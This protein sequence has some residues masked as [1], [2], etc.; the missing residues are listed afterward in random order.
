M[1]GQQHSIPDLSAR[2]EERFGFVSKDWGWFERKGFDTTSYCG[3]G[4]TTG[5][6]SGT[7]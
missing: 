5:H 7:L 1:A 3:I 6:D 4:K 2:F